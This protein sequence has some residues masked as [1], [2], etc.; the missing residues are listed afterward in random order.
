VLAQ[1][2]EPSSSEIDLGV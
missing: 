1:A 2:S